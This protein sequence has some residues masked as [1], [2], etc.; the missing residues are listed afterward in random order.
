MTIKEH[1]RANIF[2]AVPV[3]LSQLGHVMMGVMD[4]I[5]VGH[6][7]ATPLAGASLANVIFNV[8]LLFGIG[9]S[10]AMTPLIA[11]AHG[12][13]DDAIIISSFRHGFL[14]NLVFGLVLLIA[15]IVGK[16][17]LYHLDQPEEVVK[18]ALPFLSILTYSLI[19]V[20]IFQSF[21]QFADG[22]SLTYLSLVIMIA[23]NLLNV[24][25]NYTFIYGHFG[26]EPMGLVGAGYA[27][28][29]SRIFMAVALGLYVFYHT[30]LKKYRAAF[31]FKDY[32]WKHFKTL[33]TIGVPAGA[34]FVFEVAAFDFSAVMMG[35]FGTNTLAAHQIAINLATISYMTTSGLSAAAVIRIG[36]FIGQKDAINL[37]K[38]VYSLI[39]LALALMGVCGIIFLIG[40]YW[41]PS[42]Y[43]SDREVINIAA[44]LII[45]A[46]FFQLSDGMQVVCSGALR[47]LQDVK[48]PSLL[49]FI[50]YWI[51]GLPLGYWLAFKMNWG[52]NGIWIGLLVGL[53]LVSIALFIRLRTMMNRKIAAGFYPFINQD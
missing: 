26:F 25:L 45:I 31:L 13:R 29:T 47:G 18:Q 9:V 8:L 12:T 44:P 35:W 48:I 10:Y 20:L 46:G 19:P 30:K 43:I 4:N 24:L 49:I 51:I 28:L 33:L 32:S 5:M 17:L 23:A 1:I 41:L 16:N 53:T 22:L 15:V 39:G 42:L 11:Q 52:A 21:R 7:G 37:K 34:Q 38:S 6:L 36:N 3:M 27:T 50:S 2:L 40:R 14:I